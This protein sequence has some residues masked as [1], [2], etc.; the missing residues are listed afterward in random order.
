MSYEREG[1]AL[2]L[3]AHPDDFC[4]ENNPAVDPRRTWSPSRRPASS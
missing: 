1:I 2:N 4:E 3:E